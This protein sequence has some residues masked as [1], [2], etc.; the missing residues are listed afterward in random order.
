MGSVQNLWRQDSSDLLLMQTWAFISL[1]FSACREDR[2][3]KMFCFLAL[4]KDPKGKEQ[5]LGLWHLSLRRELLGSHVAVP[6]LFRQ[7]YNLD[8]PISVGFLCKRSSQKLFLVMCSKVQQSSFP[9]ISSSPPPIK[10]TPLTSVKK[11]D[12]LRRSYFCKKGTSYSCKKPLVENALNGIHLEA[13][14]CFTKNKKKMLPWRMIP[15]VL[16]S[17]C[18]YIINDWTERLFFF[19]PVGGRWMCRQRR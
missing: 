5:D 17:D 8:H 19:S 11:C 18:V 15:L 2:M 7:G 10:H 14:I 1:G 6:P 3:D 16:L 12:I 13:I 4:S 9:R